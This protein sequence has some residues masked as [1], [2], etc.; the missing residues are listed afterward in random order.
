MNRRKLFAGATGIGLGHLLA[1]AA[2]GGA[3]PKAGGTPP[4][5]LVILADDLGYG[6]LSCYGA[7]DLRTPNIDGIGT[8]GMRF[9][10]A[11]VNCPVCS[12]TRASLLTGRYPEL[13][14]VPGVI[15]THR[16]NSWG[17]L[18]P[19]AVLAP[20]LLRAAGYTSALVGKWHLGLASLN[21]PTERGFD[22]FSGFL[23]DMMDDYVT[24]RRHG[25]NYMRLNQETIDPEGHATDLF[26]QWACDYLRRQA[27]G[28]PFFLYLAYNAPHTPI[29]PPAEWLRKVKAREPAIS[30]ARAKIVALIEHMDD[31]VG[32]VLRALRE[33]D[34]EQNT[35]VLFT[36]DNGGDLPAGARN[37]P[38]RDG[39]GTLYEGGI[40]VPLLARW[41]G[42]IKPGA[43]SDHVVLTMDILPTLLEAAG[44]APPGDIDGRSFLPT[45]LAEKQPDEPR[46]LFFGRRE[47]GPFKGGTIECVRRGDW[48]LLRSRPGGP[49]ELYNLR[50]DPREERD[51]AQSEPR[52]FKELS[53]ALQ[54]QLDRYKAVPWQPPETP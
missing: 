25:Y 39:K 30:E 54:A 32:R 42:R 29:Q 2:R 47:G 20:T 12:P 44:A 16:A 22:S 45:L 23:G 3:G 27:P 5:I 8:A 6:D 17:H 15:R 43:A 51:L 53:D 9:T 34:H 18:L 35:L 40:R 26:T 11:C 31:G 49:L 41:P 48:K 21:T 38:L 24:H 19:G 28:R 33:A 7:P 4:S 14:G 52:L 13:V 36:S 10:S 1:R 46:T 37:G 50:T